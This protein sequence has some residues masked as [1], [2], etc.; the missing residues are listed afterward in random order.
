MN[1]TNIINELTDTESSLASSLLKIKVLG[2]RLNNQELVNWTNN[3]IEGY[4]DGSPLPIYRKYSCNV[5][6]N[7]QNGN[8]NL[9]NHFLPLDGFDSDLKEKIET[10]ELYHSLSGMEKLLADKST[11]RLYN[12][13]PLQLHQYFSRQLQK[14][15]NH[16]AHVYEAWRELGKGGLEQAISIIRNKA[17]DLMLML[18]QEFGY[19]IEYDKLISSKTEANK[20]IYNVLNNIYT[21]GS[22]N[23]INTGNNSNLTGN[24]KS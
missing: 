7:I 3:E 9:T 21:L 12:S 5:V 14:N 10:F 20:I 15:G 24:G 22:Q 8:W 23:I 16:N 2:V 11:D 18:E 19:E 17:L 4:T 13:L 6:G 1:I